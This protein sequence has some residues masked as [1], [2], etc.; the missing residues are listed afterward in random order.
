MEV[1]SDLDAIRYM[2]FSAGIYDAGIEDF[3]FYDMTKAQELLKDSEI[4]KRMMKDY[5]ENDFMWLM[6]NVAMGDPTDEMADDIAYAQDGGFKGKNFI[7]PQE[8]ILLPGSPFRG[9]QGDVPDDVWEQ[10]KN[11]KLFDRPK[12][13]FLDTDDEEGYKTKLSKLEKKIN[14][15]LGDPMK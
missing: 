14:K 10:F 8:E 9:I 1:K 4:W 7:G 13:S 2:L 11:N 5:N 15:K 12:P 6:N 3:D